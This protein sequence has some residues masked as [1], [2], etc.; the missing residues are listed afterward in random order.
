MSKFSFRS[1]CVLS[2]A[3]AAAL[4][5]SSAS[6]NWSSD[7]TSNLLV[8][9]H[10]DGGGETQPHIVASAD[11]G[12]YISWVDY[13]ATSS[14]RLQ[15]LDAGGNAVWGP[16]GILVYARNEGF[17]Y[18]YGLSVDTAG[19]AVLAFDAG[20][21]YV[22]GF[23]THYQPGGAIIASKIAPDGTFLWG[24]TGVQVSP[25][26]E[27]EYRGS[28][29]GTSDGNVVVG[30]F[31]ASGQSVYQ[32]LAAADGA[33]LWP[34]AQVFSGF[35]AGLQG[36]DSGNV[37][38]STVIGGALATQ[39]LAS[40]DGSPLWGANPVSVSDGQAATG[41][42]PNGYFPDLISDG[43]GGAVFYYQVDG[44]SSTTARVQHVSSVGTRLFAD[45]N[46]NGVDVSTNNSVDG[47][48]THNQDT[49][50]GAFDASTGDIYVLF[51]DWFPAGN[52]PNA[53]F[54]QRISGAGLRQWTDGGMALEP[55]LPFGVTYTTA[56]A[57]PGGVIATWSSAGS[58]AGP[59]NPTNIVA[60]RLNADGSY[61]WSSTSPAA[62]KTSAATT[63]R[64]SGVNSTQ[65]YAAFV[66]ADNDGAGGYA[67]IR[68]QNLRYDGLLGKLAGIAPGA[69]TLTA[70]TD[71]GSSNSDRVTNNPAPQFA[72][73][74]NADGD[75]VGVAVDGAIVASGACSGGIYAVT[76]ASTPADG[77]HAVE[78]YEFNANGSSPYSS[79]SSFTMDTTAPVITLNSKPANPTSA[80]SATFEFTVDG[81]QSTQCQFD[82]GAFAP[83]TSPVSYMGLAVGPHSFTV[84]AIDAAGNIGSTP[85][86]WTV[87][88]DPV[89]VS[90]DSS[91]DSG[92]SSSDLTSNANPL[93]FVGSCTDG[94]TIKVFAGAAT[95]GTTTCASGVFSVSTSALTTDGTKSISANATRG[96]LTGPTGTVLKV[97]IDRHAPLAPT[98]T[99]PSGSVGVN[100][101]VSGSAE[102]NSIVAVIENGNV[103]CNALTDGTGAW[104]CN[105]AF[106]AAG[107]NT[108]TATATD[109]AGNTSPASAPFDV[110]VDSDRIFSN[111]FDG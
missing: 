12:F 70:A 40:L 96:G 35:L 65:G 37:I 80:S 63:Y 77:A 8:A 108:L 4:A 9:Q 81:P 98:I 87:Q 31:N 47:A 2:F 44:T 78:A 36:S 52:S 107:T 32:K 82:G 28:I 99:D 71:S 20:W 79:G 33:P 84:Q 68:A 104:S 26:G 46:S 48:G 13:G 10:H 103:L 11:G 57:I 76:L 106:P 89:T 111:G 94:D 66:W 73:T 14:I 51:E 19:N 61:A 18:D 88:P 6:A 56:V 75:S 72:G 100:A 90:L 102:I 110:S 16:A 23:G 92:R 3:A 21:S 97:V 86:A 55:Y 59:V 53:T 69:P 67:D 30:W 27:T 43:A 83:C 34:S 41:T 101:A 64:L 60:T 38:L 93:T 22:D 62:V 42:L 58:V 50:A 54:A 95:L 17:T 5:A 29:T 7:P 45:N 1:A 91:T 39:K 49:P 25:L 105:A 109:V 15:R 74:C 24:A 85:Y